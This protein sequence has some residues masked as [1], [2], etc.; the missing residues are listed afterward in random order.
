MLDF[1]TLAPLCSRK[2]TF[3]VFAR[4]V[5]SVDDSSSDEHCCG[6]LQGRRGGGGSCPSDRRHD[7]CLNK[8]QVITRPYF[9]GGRNRKATLSP[10]Q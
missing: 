3:G 5:P 1:H 4:R 8:M 7:I 10:Q 6:P 2:S 9:L